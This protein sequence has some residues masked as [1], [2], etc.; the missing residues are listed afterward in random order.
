M[1]VSDRLI[2]ALLTGLCTLIFLGTVAGYTLLAILVATVHPI[3]SFILFF[4]VIPSIIAVIITY[5]ED[6]F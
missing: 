2:K 5:I 1:E 4:I 6:D 3:L